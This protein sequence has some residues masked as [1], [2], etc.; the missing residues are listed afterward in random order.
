M[1]KLAL[2]RLPDVSGQQVYQLLRS[3]QA[4]IL[5]RVGSELPYRLNKALR[6]ILCAALIPVRSNLTS[7]GKHIEMYSE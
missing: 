3:Q 5:L 6:T 1:I 4:A 2:Q 7:S